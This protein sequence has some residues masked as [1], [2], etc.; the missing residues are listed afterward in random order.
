MCVCV[1]I[2][3]L[4]FPPKQT[5]LRVCVCVAGE[6]LGFAVL[7]FCCNQIEFSFSFVFSTH[8]P[9][10][11]AHRFPVRGYGSG[12]RRTLRRLLPSVCGC[13]SLLSVCTIGSIVGEKTRVRR[14]RPTTV[15]VCVMTTTD[16]SFFS[17][18]AVLAG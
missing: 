15:C 9:Q 11:R 1:S 4:S 17:S 12:S 16:K 3:F 2:C 13:V 8:I 5:R 10:E 18:F 6:C 14:R 7:F